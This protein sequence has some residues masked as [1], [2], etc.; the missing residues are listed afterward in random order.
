MSEDTAPP[1]DISDDAPDMA[2]AELALGLLDGEDRAHALR[3]ML[4]AV[5][6]NDQ[7]SFQANKV[8]DIW[9]NRV[10]TPKFVRLK[11]PR[12]EQ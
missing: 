9:A 11:L 2:A 6:F 7:S 12:P 10:L 4:A 3:R 1:D 5:Q 8:S